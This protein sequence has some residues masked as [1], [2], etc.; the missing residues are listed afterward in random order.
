M[1]ATF[2]QITDDLAR[3]IRRQP[4][5][6]VATAPLASDGLV[7][8]SPKGGDTFAILDPVTVAYLDL[9]GSGAETIAH[10]R[11]NGRMVIMFCAFEGEAQIVRL[12]GRGE[13]I[14]PGHTEFLA[15]A[16]RFPANPGTRAVIRLHVSRISSSCGMAV[17]FMAFKEHRRELDAWAAERGPDKL[18]EY[19]RKKNTRSIEG[20]PAIDATDGA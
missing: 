8:C 1:G 18:A 20:L 13:S 11:E 10:L 2:P 17:P 6:F 16:R 9:T 3:W 4:V 7:N 14:H 12:H 19:R 15:L 5:F